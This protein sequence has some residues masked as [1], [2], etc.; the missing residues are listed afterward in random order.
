ML[1]APREKICF[2]NRDF[3]RGRHPQEAIH[4][5]KTEPKATNFDIRTS[6]A[7][8]DNKWTNDDREVNILSFWRRRRELIDVSWHCRESPQTPENLPKLHLE[9]TPR[10]MNEV[11]RWPLGL[12]S[13]ILFKPILNMDVQRMMGQRVVG[14]TD[15][16]SDFLSCYYESSGKQDR[17]SF[18]CFFYRRSSLTQLE[19][20]LASFCRSLSFCWQQHIDFS[21]FDGTPFLCYIQYRLAL[22]RLLALIFLVSTLFSAVILLIFSWAS[23]NLQK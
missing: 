12:P 13:C 18:S 6:T 5:P 15:T 8:P 7:R 16:S 9:V 10:W 19:D 2:V 17:R 14:R 21:G 11:N 3:P 20:T 22:T 23:F 4:V 1:G